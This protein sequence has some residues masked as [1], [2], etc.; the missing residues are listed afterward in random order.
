M[1]LSRPRYRCRVN[2]EGEILTPRDLHIV[3]L[4]VPR[5]LIEESSVSIDRK[6]FP[7]QAASVHRASLS[8]LESSLNVSQIVLQ[9]SMVPKR[10]FVFNASV[11]H[12]MTHRE[13]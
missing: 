5:F 2:L 10:S 8:S 11:E 6:G 13:R 1:F 9:R 12:C 7:Y 3:E 4:E